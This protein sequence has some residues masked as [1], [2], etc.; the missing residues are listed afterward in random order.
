MP[1]EITQR[2]AIDNITMSADLETIVAEI[3]EAA[4]ET[5]YK[6]GVYRSL[7]TEV[8]KGQKG[9]SVAIPR[10][11]QQG[12]GAYVAEEGV[13]INEPEKYANTVDTISA[14]EYVKNTFITYNDLEDAND[15][16]RKRHAN[17]IGTSIGRAVEE[18]GHAAGQTFTKS[19]TVAEGE[20]F[21]IVDIVK[22]K[23]LIEAG[24]RVEE[25]S[26]NCVANSYLYSDLLLSMTDKSEYGVRGDLGNTFLDKYHVKT[27]LG[28]VDLYR[29]DILADTTTETLDGAF[30]K[31]TAMGIFVPRTFKLEEDHNKQL[32]GYELIATERVGFGVIDDGL[33]VKFTAPNSFYVA[34]EEP[35]VP[36]G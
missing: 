3:R 22:M 23:A 17:Y 4:E 24:N 21:S 35:V 15:D 9:D 8:G 32:R 30:F 20:A 11:T 25:G 33:G 18:A 1:E 16:V 12:T 31:K 2:P 7:A 10:W 29:A 5:L 36:E 6:S 13:M 28:N 27:I 19:H 26:Y 34:P 14:V